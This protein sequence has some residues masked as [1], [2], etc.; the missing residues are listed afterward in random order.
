MSAAEDIRRKLARLR[1]LPFGD[2]TLEKLFDLF[3]KFCDTLDETV[4]ENTD[5]RARHIALC[6]VIDFQN[7]RMMAVHAN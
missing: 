3:E 1:A 7:A 5:L 4:A 2:D 6:R